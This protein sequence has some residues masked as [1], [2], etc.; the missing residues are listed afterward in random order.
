MRRFIVPI[1]L[2]LGVLV[3]VTL[4]RHG[5]STAAVATVQANPTQTI[6]DGKGN[7]PS[8][9]VNSAAFDSQKLTPAQV[10][11]ITNAAS[12]AAPSDRNKLRW[13]A[14]TGKVIVFV[15][16]EG[17]GPMV[18]LAAQGYRAFDSDYR[19]PDGGHLVYGLNQ[20]PNSPCTIHAV[21]PLGE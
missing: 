11:F 20:G 8:F 19:N 1:V 16:L 7:C 21:N 2:V 4:E 10:S 3:V 17:W 14:I 5:G 12:R 9:P 6:A 15:P 18:V 13:A